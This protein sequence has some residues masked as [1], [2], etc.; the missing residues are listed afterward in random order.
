MRTFE[1]DGNITTSTTTADLQAKMNA[2]KKKKVKV[3][4]GIAYM[5]AA[6]DVLVNEGTML[7]DDNSYSYSSEELAARRPVRSP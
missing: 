7:T 3:E 1:K 4:R 5:P 2:L 6:V